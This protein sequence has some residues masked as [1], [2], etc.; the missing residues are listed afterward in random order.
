LHVNCGVSCHNDNPAAE[1][2]SSDLRLVL[3]AHQLDG[4]ESTEYAAI[5]TAVGIE[6]Q[7]PGWSNTTRIVPGSP[8]DSLLYHLANRRDPANPDEQMPPIASR[9]LDT[10][11]LSTI[12][13]WIRSMPDD[14][15]TE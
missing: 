7:T 10:E 4:S 13:R 15:G 9:L 5:R 3:E 11:G 1:G 8:E 12:E 6:A 14:F 2:Y